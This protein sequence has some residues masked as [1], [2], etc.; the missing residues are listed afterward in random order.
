VAL[1]WDPEKDAQNIVRRGFSFAIVER[2]DW[3]SAL[4]VEDT[5]ADYGERRFISV[6]WIDNELFVVVWTPRGEAVRVISA[7]KASARERKLY[8]EEA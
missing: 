3:E 2:L 5:R 7:R 6:G 8:E 4:T 1:E